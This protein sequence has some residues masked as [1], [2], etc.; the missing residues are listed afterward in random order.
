MTL[1]LCKTAVIISESLGM[2][3]DVSFVSVNARF[4]PDFGSQNSLLEE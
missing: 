1:S 2:R 4:K 3:S